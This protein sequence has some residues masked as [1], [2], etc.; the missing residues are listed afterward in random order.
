[1]PQAFS[2]EGSG[3]LIIPRDVLQRHWRTCKLRLDIGAEIP[4]YSHTS[5]PNKR[6][7]CD[8]CARLKKACSLSSPCEACRARNHECSYGDS[9]PAAESGALVQA[10][11]PIFSSFALSAPGETSELEID[12]PCFPPLEIPNLNMTSA[13]ETGSWN[14]STLDSW[15]EEPLPSILDS[16]YAL[17]FPSNVYDAFSG[18]QSAYPSSIVTRL[19]FLDHFTS[20]TGFADSFECGSATEMK[21]LTRGVQEESFDQNSEKDGTSLGQLF[22][23]NPSSQDIL[24]LSDFTVPTEVIGNPQQARGSLSFFADVPEGMYFGCEDWL[25]DS[26]VGVTNNIVSG[27]KVAT[28]HRSPCSPITFD[29]STLIEQICVQFFS[30][31]NIKKYLLFFWSFWYPNC[32]IIHKPTFDIHNAPH[33]LLVPMLLIGASLFPDESVKR[34]AKLWFSSAEEMA[35]AE[36]HFQ[37]SITTKGEN[38]PPRRKTLQALQAAYLICLLQN[39]EGD[40]N[41]KQR[42]R[43]YRYSMVI[44]VYP[45][46]SLCCMSRKA[47]LF[48]CFRLRETLDL[49]PETIMRSDYRTWTGIVLSWKRSWLGMIFVLFV[50]VICPL[51]F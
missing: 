33:T 41:S 1:M 47:N 21:D 18:V 25:S 13:G 2:Q 6:R 30:P 4:R 27:L 19:Y 15:A 38:H 36:E 48:R 23:L 14:P 46:W 12:Q 42:I 22:H 28:Q 20:V 44:T 5:R 50:P 3:L 7:A 16:E 17:N 31:P 8:R 29:W 49:H 34:N 39:W 37:H 43:C 9:H 51:E 45:A 40:N 35:F 11:S 24:Q 32:P 26:L 10:P